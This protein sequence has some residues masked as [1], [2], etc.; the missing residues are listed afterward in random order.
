VHDI[1]LGY[2]L[3]NV[4]SLM[5]CGVLPKILSHLGNLTGMKS[6]GLIIENNAHE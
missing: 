2:I 5:M 4:G 1:E 3:K 6:S